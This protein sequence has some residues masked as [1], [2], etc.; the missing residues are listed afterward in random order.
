MKNPDQHNLNLNKLEFSPETSTII[1]DIVPLAL[2]IEK[3]KEVAEENGLNLKEEFHSTIIGRQVSNIITARVEALP[4]LEQLEIRAS[5]KNLAKKFHWNYS[6]QQNF[7]Y[8]SN[9][10]GRNE[11]RQ[12]IV[13]MIDFPDIVE[14]YVELNDLLNTKFATPLPHVTL[15]TTSTREDNKLR[16]IAIDSVEHFWLLNPI[17]I[18]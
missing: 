16:G 13:Q 3:V 14:F 18:G 17:K 15:Y 4:H 1:L 10:Y 6:L 7:F 9:E 2:D 5:V 12:S 11:K 8:I